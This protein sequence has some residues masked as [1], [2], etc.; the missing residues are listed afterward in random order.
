MMMSPA[1][2]FYAEPELGKRQVRLAFV[3]EQ[4]KLKLALECLRVALEK[5]PAGSPCRSGSKLLLDT[6]S[7]RER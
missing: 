6:T 3:L 2:G 7:T 5:Y 4:D 1:S